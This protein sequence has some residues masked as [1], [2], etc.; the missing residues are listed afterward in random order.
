MRR[1][2]SNQQNRLR[3]SRM[4]VQSLQSFYSYGMNQD[5]TKWQVCLVDIWSD[6]KASLIVMAQFD[7]EADAI[8]KQKEL[9]MDKDA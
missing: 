4:S 9:Q 7:N 5:E 2:R 8:K 1:V 3:T 6:G